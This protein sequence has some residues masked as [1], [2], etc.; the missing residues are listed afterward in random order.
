MWKSRGACPC[1]HPVISHQDECA[2]QMPVTANTR[3]LMDTMAPL[4][5]SVSSSPRRL[6]AGD[7]QSIWL[8]CSGGRLWSG[9]RR[10]P[11]A[12]CRSLPAVASLPYFFDASVPTARAERLR[13]RPRCYPPLLSRYTHSRW[14]LQLV[15]A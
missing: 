5:P 7:A 3:L 13:R 14:Q 10:S 1:L 4:G 12:S 8:R 2:N 6:A 15:T 9:A 11:R